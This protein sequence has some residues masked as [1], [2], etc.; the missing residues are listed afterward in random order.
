MNR[1]YRLIRTLLL[2]ST[3]L[4]FASAYF[5]TPL[6]DPVKKRYHINPES[7][8]YLKGTTNV[9]TFTC[10][11]TDRFQP[12]YL[13]V[14]SQ[15][16]YAHFRRAGLHISTRDFNCHNRKIE[17]DMEKALKADTYPHIGI[18][19]VESWQNGQ[20]LNADC[21][22]WFSVKAK[23]KITITDVDKQHQILGKARRIGANRFQLV[24]EKALQ[25]SEFGIDPPHAMFGMIKVNDWITF[26]FDLIVEVNDEP[27]PQGNL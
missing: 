1:R 27:S 19:L 15:G 18:E 23:V 17:A 2:L 11:C 5:H 12:Q 10:D 7:K 25:M 9:N 21:R 22:D 6:A 3:S 20:C 16:T 14:E 26:H 24:G 4:L 13:E 8:L